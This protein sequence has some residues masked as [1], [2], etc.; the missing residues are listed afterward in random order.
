MANTQV[1]TVK[2]NDGN[3]MPQLGLGVWKAENGGETEQAVRDAIR[4]GYRLIDTAMV[5]KNEEDVGRA[6]AASDVPRDELFITTKLWN[7][8][9]GAENVRPAFMKSLEKLGLDYI[10]LYLIHWPTP[11]R[12]LYVETWREFEKL[13]DEGLVKS[14]GVSNFEPEHLER[15]AMETGTVPVVNQVEL[16][17][18]FN[19]AELREY[20]LGKDIRVES[21]SPIGGSRG[22]TLE[23]ETVQKI[24]ATHGKTPAQVVIRWHLQHSLIVIPKSVRKERIEENIDV[25]DFELSSEEMSVIDGIEGNRQGPDPKDMNVH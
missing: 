6:I 19:Q 7:S 11:G 20:C 9:Q 22:N 17:P 2:L 3:M 10:D 23:N 24:A 15:L 1:P 12:D 18:G 16:H 5:Y 21:W 13:R 4:A 25:F 8:D 14:I